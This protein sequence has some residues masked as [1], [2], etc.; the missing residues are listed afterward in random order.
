MTRLLVATLW[1][2]GCGSSGGFNKGSVDAG[3]NDGGGPVTCSAALSACSGQCVDLKADDKNCGQCG[4]SC[5]N[6]SCVGGVCM[7]NPCQAPEQLCGGSCVNVTNNAE[8]CGQCSHACPQGQQCANSK[9]VQPSTMTGCAGCVDCLNNC[10]QG[11]QSCQKGCITNTTKQGQALLQTLVTCFDTA[12]PT[13][14]GGVCADMALNDDGK[15]CDACF[16]K[17]QMHNGECYQKL[18]DCSANGP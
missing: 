11:D 14:N 12:C 8:N 13:D 4:K 15:K 6:Q 1:L 18:A 2:V 7:N 9:C 16:Q 17:A 3:T 5:G 10:T